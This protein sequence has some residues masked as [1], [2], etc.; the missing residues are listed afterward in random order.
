MYYKMM[1][2]MFGSTELALAAYNAG[3]VAVKRQKA[4]P[5][6]SRSFVNTIMADYRYYTK[7]PDPAM[8]QAAKKAPAV[9]IRPKPVISNKPAVSTSPVTNGNSAGLSKHSLQMIDVS[10]TKTVKDSLI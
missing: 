10:A 8:V 9:N 4:V 2:K 6:I 3:P 1:Y 5:G 7:N